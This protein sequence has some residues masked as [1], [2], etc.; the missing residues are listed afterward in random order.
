MN[1]YF[2]CN[3]EK[4]CFMC[5]LNPS[6]LE[7]WNCEVGCPERMLQ[8]YKGNFSTLWVYAFTLSWLFFYSFLSVLGKFAA[9]STILHAPPV[10]DRAVSQQYLMYF[11]SGARGS[12]RLLINIASCSNLGPFSPSCLSSC[13]AFPFTSLSVWPFSPSPWSQRFGLH[14]SSTSGTFTVTLFWC[15]CWSC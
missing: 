9:S 3:Q 12:A 7:A 1:V 2:S 6:W 11:G 8:E 14:F 13:P 15:I 5:V 4:H 10:T